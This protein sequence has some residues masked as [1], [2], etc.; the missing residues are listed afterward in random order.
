MSVCRLDQHGPVFDWNP[1]AIV[2]ALHRGVV[3]V[4]EH[5][6]D[7][8]DTAEAPDDFAMGFHSPHVRSQRTSVNVE[9]GHGI[10]D[11]AGMA[12]STIGEKLIALRKR[13]GL[14][15]EKVAKAMGLA[16]RSS[17]Q[18]LFD[19]SIDQ[20]DLGDAIKLADAMAGLGVPPI[21]RQEILS[22]TGLT[23]L[24][25]AVPNGQLAPKYM[26]LPRDVPVYFTAMG[27]YRSADDDSQAIEQAFIDPSETLDHFERPPG[28]LTRGGLYGVYIQGDSM[29]PRWES[30]DPCY[31]DPKKTP[32]IGDDV[33]VYLV[34][35]IGEE[36]E[37]AAVLIKRLVKRSAGFIELRQFNPDITFRVETR[38]IQAIHRVIPRRELLTVR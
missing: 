18:R 32:H 7:F 19:A 17:V 12:E 26:D 5:P 9:N 3:A 21:E 29:E 15:M 28:Y 38:H 11:N 1:V 25:E 36:Q 35:G 13:S 4:I 2:P 34:R 33:I 14:S 23:Q 10:Q 8:A 27:T 16:G 20:L 37:M 24:I 6:S 30:G 22:L 31:A